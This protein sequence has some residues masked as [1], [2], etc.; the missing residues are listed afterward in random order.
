MK[1][2]P[3]ILSGGSGTRLWPLS[4]PETPKQFL[5]LASSATMFEETLARVADSTRFAPPLIVANARHEALMRSQLAGKPAT[6]LLEPC[7]RNTAPAIALAAL[8]APDSLLLVMPSDHV[9]ENVA[10]FHAIIAEAE[11]LA[12]ADWLI[13]FGITPHAPETGYGYIHMGEPLLPHVRRAHRFVEKP[14]QEV[15]ETMLHEGGYVWNAG[16]FLFHARAYLAALAK[17]DPACLKACEAAMRNARKEGDVIHPA[18][19]DFAQA[20]SD[21]IDYAVMEKA[22]HVAVAQVDMG[23]SDLGSW[24]ALADLLPKDAAG[25]AFQGHVLTH[26]TRNCVVRSVAGKRIALIGVEDLVVIASGDDILIM[27]KGQ[28]QAVKKIVEQL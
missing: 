9:I 10:A 12:D 13:T 25:N 26:D 6:F 17:H 24:D 16:I 7:A 21:S 5:P 18:E 20:P 2:I 14:K 1:I 4:T 23:W 3:V 27:P 19:A 15:A 8:H 22:A 11:E 28:S